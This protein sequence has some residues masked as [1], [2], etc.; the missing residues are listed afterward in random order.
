MLVNTQVLKTEGDLGGEKIAMSIDENSLNHLMSVL[1]D[2]YSD[3]IMAVVREYSTNALDSHLASGQTKSVQVSTPTALNPYF[4]VRDFGVGMDIDDIRNIYSKYGASSK[5]N[6]NVESGMLGLGCKSG[7][8]YSNQFTLTGIKNGIKTLVSISRSANGAGQMEVVDESPTTDSNGVI[9]K[10]PVNNNWD[11]EEFERK[12]KFFAQ[13]VTP[14]QYQVNGNDISNLDFTVISDKLW[15]RKVHWNMTEQDRKCFVVMG[16]VAYPIDLDKF[17]DLKNVVPYGHS[18]VFFADMG[19]VDFPPSREELMYTSRTN[20]TLKQMRTDIADAFR[21]H[22]QHRI[23]N[24]IDIREAFTTQRQINKE[25][26]LTLRFEFEGEEL[27]RVIEDVKQANWNAPSTDPKNPESAPTYYASEID[28]APLTGYLYITD[29]K[30]KKFVRVHGRKIEKYVE[31]VAAL[32]AFKDVRTVFLMEEFPED[33][34]EDIFEGCTFVSWDDIKKLKVDAAPKRV[35]AK[36]KWTNYYKQQVVPDETKKIYYDNR[37]HL[38]EQYAHQ[39]HTSDDSEFYWVA[40]SQVKRFKELNPNAE[41][42]S[43]YCAN[44]VVDWVDNLTKEELQ[45]FQL[46]TSFRGAWALNA[47]NILDPELRIIAKANEEN[48]KEQASSLFRKRNLM[49]NMTYYA[50]KTILG[51]T[52]VPQV[53]EKGDNII[54]RYPLLKHSPDTYYINDKTRYAEDMTLYVNYMHLKRTKQLEDLLK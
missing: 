35:K 42:S 15:I 9:V 7:L 39:I 43:V 44:A 5:R 52:K 8:T 51:N 2:L 23:D 46:Y 33:I 4:V 34:N 13:F 37:N 32:S 38:P 50:D 47:S 53:V 40:D 3:K 31:S 49:D 28:S 6:N 12:A 41:H 10:I 14:G 19:D 11:R 21:Q 54:A 24:C 30:N 29:W 18:F 26:I 48:P 27:P 22:L 17:G 1:S 25:Y 45:S 16:N 36:R 20:A